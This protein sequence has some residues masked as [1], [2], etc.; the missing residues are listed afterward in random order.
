MGNAIAHHKEKGVMRAMWHNLRRFKTEQTENKRS[1]QA[2]MYGWCKHLDVDVLLFS[3][4]GLA[5][6]SGKTGHLNRQHRSGQMAHRASV[7]WDGEGMSWA[8]SP[9]RMGNR[10]RTLQE[11]MAAV[12]KEEEYHTKGGTLIALSAKWVHRGDMVVS[13]KSCLLYTSPSPRD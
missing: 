5:L 10:P 9:G 4:T 11:R 1:H 3:D 2:T 6:P 13:D 8:I 7:L 12:A